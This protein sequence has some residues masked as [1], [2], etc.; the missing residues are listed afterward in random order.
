LQRLRN[1]Y[2]TRELTNGGDGRHYGD[3]VDRL[4]TS[5]LRSSNKESFDD[6]TVYLLGDEVVVKEFLVLN[7]KTGKEEVRKRFYCVLSTENL[8]LNAVRQQATGQE[9]ALAVDASYRYVVERDHGLFVIKCINH[10]Q[11]AKHLAYAICNKEDEEAIK[12]IFE[13]VKEEVERVV[14]GRLDNGEE[15]F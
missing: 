7:P 8:L 15:W 14:N 10:G 9:M 3:V 5:F 11:S 13:S 12:W 1:K 6:N 2:D 4:K